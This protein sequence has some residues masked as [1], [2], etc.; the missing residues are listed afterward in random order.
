MT[1]IDAKE[2][3]TRITKNKMSEQVVKWKQNKN[4][5][6]ALQ[7]SESS[8]AARDEHARRVKKGL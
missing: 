6:H 1:K 7:N 5:R 2:A 8:H 3:W 4:S